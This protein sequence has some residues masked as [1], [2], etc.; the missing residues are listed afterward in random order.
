MRLEQV[1]DAYVQER[2]REAAAAQ[3]RIEARRQQALA[4]RPRVLPCGFC[5][6]PESRHAGA[7]ARGMVRLGRRNAPD[8]LT[9]RS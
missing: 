8:G 9:D 5:L 1:I 3:L 7:L 2:R 6:P 4:S